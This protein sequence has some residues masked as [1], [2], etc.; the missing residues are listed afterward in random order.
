VSAF[1]ERPVLSA[2]VMG[3][4]NERTIVQS[5]ASLL[6]QETEESFEVLVVTSGVD[7][8]AELVRKH[9]P[10]LR[11]HDSPSRLMPGAARNIGVRLARGNVIAFLAG[12]CLASPGWIANR[13]AAHRAGHDVVAGAVSHA[14]RETFAARAALFSTF[15]ARLTTRPA[16]PADASNVFGLSYIRSLLDRVGPFEEGTGMGED[17]LMSRWLKSLG[18]PVWFEPSVHAAHFGPESTLALLREQYARGMRRAEW[19]DLVCP[20]GR[21]RQRWDRMR[22]PGAQL[23]TVSLLAGRQ[24]TNR[25]RWTIR[26]VWRWNK[27]QR[28]HVLAV[29][30]WMVAAT[31]VNEI[32]W[33]ASQLGTEGRARR[34]ARS[35]GRPSRWRIIQSLPPN[36]SAPTAALTFDDG[37]CPIS[38]PA[39]LET[40]QRYGVQAT[41]FMLGREAARHP[42][43]VSRVAAAGHQ[44]GSHGWSHTDLTLLDDA[45]L[46]TELDR[47]NELLGRLS[48]RAV[49]HVRPPGGRFNSVVT[50]WVA[51]RGLHTVLW[52]IDPTD[53][54]QPTE[55]GVAS[56][57]FDQ[58]RPEA[59][60]LLHDTDNSTGTIEALPSIIEGI[61]ARG[62]R[63]VTL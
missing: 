45:A 34:R 37:P 18:I 29:L 43:L 11:V 26:S 47:T 50:S 12:D 44:I 17:T 6:E 39:I 5:V 51:G 3:Y 15:P 58:L 62:Y 59:V 35:S 27:G 54:E 49:R 52:S 23:V 42:D 2:I 20:I 56:H 16:G 21:R 4:R 33:A 55:V 36:G 9:Y 41:F 38:T 19:E 60:I 61:H 8:S 32:G 10:Q 25:W 40:L 1:A 46:E 7:R 57:I 28:R 13:I 53:W 63:L 24:F 31:G 48:G 30:P 14:G 22:W